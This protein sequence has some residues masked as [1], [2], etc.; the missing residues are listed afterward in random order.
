MWGITRPPSCPPLW[1][2][3]GLQPCTLKTSLLDGIPNSASLTSWQVSLET[4]GAPA[5]SGHSHTLR[6][7]FQFELRLHPDTPAHPSPRT[8][9]PSSPRMSLSLGT[10]PNSQTSPTGIPQPDGCRASPLFPI[11]LPRPPLGSL[12]LGLRVLSAAPETID[13]IHLSKFWYIDFLGLL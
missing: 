13:F 3:G 6:F 5:T 2:S 12:N 9:S 10:S 11:H 1:V 8:P 7:H 4:E